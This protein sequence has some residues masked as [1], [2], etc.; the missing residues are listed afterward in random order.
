MTGQNVAGKRKERF[1]VDAALLRELGERL[2]GAPHIALAELIKNSYD[3][4]ATRVQIKFTDDRIDVSDNGHGMDF[5]EFRN[6]WMRVGSPHKVE[7]ATSRRL[8]R[9][10]TGSKGI[11]RLAV[12]FLGSK[13]EMRTV[14]ERDPAREL[15]ASIDWETAVQAGELTEAT[16]LY[17]V[18]RPE[19]GFPDGSSS[20]TA[21]SIE[22]LQE[23]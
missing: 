3:A 14:S 11:G 7:E 16:A 9:P 18:K 2:V 19:R 13:L 10:L 21:I 8:G 17:E 1:T 4:D 23:E 15:T 12:Q 5:E 6:R 20:G 22:G